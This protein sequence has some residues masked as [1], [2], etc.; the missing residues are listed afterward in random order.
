MQADVIIYTLVG[1][2]GMEEMFELW[3]IKLGISAFYEQNIQSL[4]KR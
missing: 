3:K 4:L 2:T 1:V